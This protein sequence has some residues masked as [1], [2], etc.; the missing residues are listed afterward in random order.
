MSAGP[1]R[2][3]GSTP[4]AV[5]GGRPSWPRRRAGSALCEACSVLAELLVDLLARRAHGA[6]G[7]RGLGDR[8]HLAAQ[9]LHEG[10]HDRALGDLVLLHVVEDLVCVG[11]GGGAGAP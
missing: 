10:P 1:R 9:R 11:R 6:A 4:A 3:A 2:Y 5:A 7:L 8:E